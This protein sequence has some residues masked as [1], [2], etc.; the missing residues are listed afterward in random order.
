MKNIFIWFAGFFEDQIGSAS[1][2]RA[3][4]YIF[5]FF[6]FLIVKG[7]LDGKTIDFN[8]LCIVAGIIAFCIG[9]ITTEFVAMFYK[10]PTDKIE[11]K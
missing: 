1:S 7:N 11:D 5:C 8:I 10:K 2:K 4:L 9:A 6:M 3:V